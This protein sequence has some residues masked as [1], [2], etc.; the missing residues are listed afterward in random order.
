MVAAGCD[1]FHSIDILVNNAGGGGSYGRLH[2]IETREFDWTINANLR[3][4][5]Y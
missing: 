2:E 1:A 5:F 4:T 3:S